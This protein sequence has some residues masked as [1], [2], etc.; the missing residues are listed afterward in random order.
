[1]RQDSVP[2]GGTRGAWIGAIEGGVIGQTAGAQIGGRSSELLQ[3]A[4]AS[5]ST[6]R[7]THVAAASSASVTEQTST[8]VAHIN[9]RTALSPSLTGPTSLGLMQ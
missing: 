8:T 6:H 1:M 3:I 2:I 9:R 7:Q 4:R 5:P